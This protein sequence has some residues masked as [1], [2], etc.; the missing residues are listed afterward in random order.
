MAVIKVF[1][2]RR[3]DLQAYYYASVVDS[4]DVAVDLTGASAVFSMRSVDGTLKIDRKAAV[5]TAATSGYLE[6]RWA[7]GDTDTAGEYY[8]E[9]EITP[10]SGGKFTLPAYD[11][12]V[13]IITDDLDTQ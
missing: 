6:Y 11:K 5:I 9:F 1:R 10:S 8:I 3:G 2:M 12:A 7:S 4:D 13:V